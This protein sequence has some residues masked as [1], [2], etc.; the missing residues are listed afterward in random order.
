MTWGDVKEMQQNAGPMELLP[1]GYLVEPEMIEQAKHRHD[2]EF[3]FELSPE[4]IS[5]A[6]RQR[7]PRVPREG[8]SLRYEVTVAAN[9]EV[10]LLLLFVDD[11][12]YY[13]RTKGEWIYIGPEDD[14]AGFFDEN[15][16]EVPA[17]F[18]AIFDA[19]P[20]PGPPLTLPVV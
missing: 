7:W 14:V 3:F 5:E 18:V 13:Y 16:L 4:A 9:G 12:Y 11:E 8:E 19:H 2:D 1:F 10:L 15:I 17:T 6:R 20:S